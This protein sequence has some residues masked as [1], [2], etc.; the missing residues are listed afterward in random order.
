MILE[1]FF[2]FEIPIGKKADDSFFGGSGLSE[3]ED[4]GRRGERGKHFL[5]RVIWIENQRDCNKDAETEN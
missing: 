5:F 3:R 4:L 1:I 2:L